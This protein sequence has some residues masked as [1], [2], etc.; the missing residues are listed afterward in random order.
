MK[1]RYFAL[2]QGRSFLFFVPSFFGAF[3]FSILGLA[4]E[5]NSRPDEPSEISVEWYHPELLS[6]PDTRLSVVVLSGKTRRGH[7]VK[8]MGERIPVFRGEGRVRFLPARVALGNGPREAVA[9]PNGVF[10]MILN[11]PLGVVQ[12]PV[13]VSSPGGSFQ[14]FRLNFHLERG[15]ASLSIGEDQKEISPKSTISPEEKN[16][17]IVSERINRLT[18]GLGVNFIRYSQSRSDTPTPLVYQPIMGPGLFA[19]LHS[20]KS[21]R[22]KKKEPRNSHW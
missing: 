22:S 15:K 4:D 7:R 2:N 1:R 16:P 3:L 8:I 12:V 11:L 17:V 19:V 5:A 10:R 9:T 21:W 6:S 20:R 18:F 14:N 13:Q